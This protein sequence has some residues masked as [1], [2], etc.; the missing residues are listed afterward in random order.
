M[1]GRSCHIAAQVAGEHEEQERWHLVEAIALHKQA[2]KTFAEHG[3]RRQ[4][5]EE[6]GKVSQLQTA[7]AVWDETWECAPK[8]VIA[9][10]AAVKADVARWQQLLQEHVG[11][12]KSLAA[13]IAKNLV[14][15]N[16]DL[17]SLA[18]QKRWN[19]DGTALA[20]GCWKIWNLAHPMEMGEDLPSFA[21]FAGLVGD[22]KGGDAMLAKLMELADSVGVNPGLFDEALTFMQAEEAEQEWA[23]YASALGGPRRG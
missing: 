11:V 19:L 12:S 8:E 21:D 16:R 6:W 20:I 18:R 1:E 14:S 7:L 17:P 15:S 4:A 5:D 10:L 13:D 2:A 9:K 23:K 3:L 22:P